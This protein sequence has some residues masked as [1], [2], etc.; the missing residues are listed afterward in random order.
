MAP[1]AFSLLAQNFCTS[2]AQAARNL[3][4]ASCVA[5]SGGAQLGADRLD[6]VGVVE[7]AGGLEAG[8]AGLALADPLRGELAGLDVLEDALH[9]GAR[10]LRHE[11]RARHVL[12]VFRRVGDR[13]V[14][15]GDAAL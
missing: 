7:A 4:R 11:A 8:L 12:A 2:A 1:L 5:L 10:L 3:A 15:V 6:L 9:L 13:V 14:H